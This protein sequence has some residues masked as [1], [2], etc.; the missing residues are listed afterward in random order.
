MHA[1]NVA[2]KAGAQPHEIEAVVTA[3]SAQ[4]EWSEERARAILANLRMG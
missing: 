4:Q 3:M 2:V 1:R